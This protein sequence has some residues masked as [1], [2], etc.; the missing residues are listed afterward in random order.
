MNKKFNYVGLAVCALGI[1]YNVATE[2]FI[3][4]SVFILIGLALI[5]KLVMSNKSI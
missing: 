1:A 3:G 5:L 2:D 4:L